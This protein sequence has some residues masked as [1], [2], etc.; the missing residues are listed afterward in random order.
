MLS[1]ISRMQE[2][3]YRMIPLTGGTVA[4][5]TETQSRMVIARNREEG[6]MGC[7]WS[8]GTASVLQDVKSFWR[9][10]A[11]MAAQRDFTPCR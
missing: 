9:W 1:E 7:F 4:K 5:I 3:R 10:T 11:E 6:R 2:D 8:M